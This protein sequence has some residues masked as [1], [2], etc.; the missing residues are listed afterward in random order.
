[1]KKK[2]REKSQCSDSKCHL[3]LRPNEELMAK[4]EEPRDR[5]NNI[6]ILITTNVLKHLFMGKKFW[7][8]L[9]QNGS[10]ACVV[11]FHVPLPAFHIFIV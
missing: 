8:E 5:I 11:R 7:K 3:E 1:M 10:S 4:A 6:P 2:I 9:H